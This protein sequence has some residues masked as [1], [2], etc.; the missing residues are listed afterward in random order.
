[1]KHS[2]LGIAAIFCILFLSSCSPS[3]GG[4]GWIAPVGLG[5]ASVWTF[6]R[7]FGVV[8]SVNKDT[9]SYYEKKGQN[10]TLLYAI[11]WAAACIGVIIWMASEG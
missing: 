5:L 4:G 11:I 9:R 3:F 8:K 10:G 1:M 2:K 6:L 7:Y